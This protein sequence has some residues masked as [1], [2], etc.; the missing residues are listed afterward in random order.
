MSHWFH[1][2]NLKATTVISYDSVLFG[3]LDMVRL[4]SDLKKARDRLLELLPDPS[5]NAET[6]NTAYLAY[7]SI[8]SG[9]LT[10]Y[11]LSGKKIRYTIQYKWTHTLLGQKPQSQFDAAYDIANMSVD[12]A[13]WHMKHASY[14]ASK[15][16]VIMDDAKDIHTALR[17]AAGIFQMIQKDI[18]PLIE[19]RLLASDL[20]L[21]ILKAYFT[22]CTAEAQEVTVARAIELKHNNSLISSLAY[23][24]SK[25]FDN[26][27]RCLGGLDRMLTEQWL[28]YLNIKKFIYLA[29]AYCYCGKNLLEDDHCGEAIRA[30]R[31]SQ[32]NYKKALQLCKP[33]STVK[34]PAKPVRPEGHIFFTKID[35]TVRLILE[36]CERENGF[37]YHQK[38]PD[39]PPELETKATYGLVSPEEYHLPPPAPL[40]ECAFDNEAKLQSLKPD[41]GAATGPEKDLPKVVEIGA[42]SKTE[43]IKDDHGCMI[44]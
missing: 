24:T 40:W 29:Y 33:Y 21:K 18:V 44:Q 7:L 17:K 30:L 27:V 8:M 37:I 10:E 34:G 4:A 28:H 38:V 42:D 31:E 5:Q 2:S 15:K 3:G 35:S 23:E 1:R 39:D 26:A 9:F 32:A 22:Q 13:L 36:K 25:L 20:D 19:H 14:V 41:N 12:V 16:S 43:S 11:K 6:V